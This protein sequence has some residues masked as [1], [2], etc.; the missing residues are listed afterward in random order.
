MNRVL[1]PGTFDPITKGHADLVERASRLFDHVV[2]AVAASPKKNPLFPLEQRVELCRE[3]TAHLPNVTVVGFSS[4]L[5]HFVKEQNANI[6]LRGLRAVSDFEYEFQLANMNRQLA[7][8]IESMFLTP[9]EK[10]SFI[11]STLVREIAALGGDITKFVH[12]VV[13]TAL[14]ERFQ[15]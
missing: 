9:S 12:P 3:V 13:A 8:D 2:I 5:V 10:Y 7:P 4:L 14:S 1:Y 15:R 11:S 6:L